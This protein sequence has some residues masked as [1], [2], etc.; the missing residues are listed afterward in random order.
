MA[1]DAAARE[2]AERLA[3]ACPREHIHNGLALADAGIPQCGGLACSE[4]IAVGL[5]RARREA[6]EEAAQAMCPLCDNS[7]VDNAK[8]LPAYF[9]SGK[10]THEIV[11]AHGITWPP[12]KA[13]PIRALV[14]G[15]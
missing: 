10:W 3:E 11:W 15:P 8:I 13:A 5:A 9:A 14:A 7:P 1:D 12:C 4:C 6:L 2:E